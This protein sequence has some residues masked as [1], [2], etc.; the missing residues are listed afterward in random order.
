MSEV[1]EFAGHRVAPHRPRPVL[2]ALLVA[3]GLFVA[4]FTV[5]LFIFERGN[6][7]QRGEVQE[8]LMRSA[9]IAALLIDGDAHR[10]FLS[11]EQEGSEA[12]ATAIAPLASILADNEDLRYIYTLVSVDG[13]PHFV[14]DPTPPGVD[15]DEDGVE[16]KS[17][18]MERYDA[19]S[20]V[21]VTALE[22]CAAGSGARCAAAAEEELYTDAWGTFISAY[23]PFYDS[24]GEFVGLV[25]LDLSAE[26][27]LG[28]LAPLERATDRAMVTGF[29][30]SF[31][32][33]TWIWFTRKYFLVVSRSRMSILTD[34]RRAAGRMRGRGHAPPI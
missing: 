28:R 21:L 16:D 4:V 26:N 24:A 31:L 30:A 34:L 9:S 27:Y 11:R 13:L 1:H 14:L 15:E 25:G 19:P 32:I 5:S 22:N 6:A 2:E 29:F 3:G 17:H 12:Y 10:S 8:G 23:A 33:G 7:A 20:P 18:V